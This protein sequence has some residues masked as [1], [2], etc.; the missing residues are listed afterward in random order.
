MNLVQTTHRFNTMAM[1]TYLRLVFFKAV[2]MFDYFAPMPLH[3]V[4]QAGIFTLLM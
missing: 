2:G 3:F 1:L 4:L